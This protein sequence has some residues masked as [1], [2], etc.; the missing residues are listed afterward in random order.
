MR[1]SNPLFALRDVLLDEARAGASVLQPR[2]LARCPHII[3]LHIMH[4]PALAGMISVW[5]EC[6]LEN[7]HYARMHSDETVPLW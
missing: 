4:H 5:V 2:Q 6:L 1:R 7:G 3:V